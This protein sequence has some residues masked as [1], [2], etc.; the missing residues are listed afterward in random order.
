MKWN[1]E[2]FAQGVV[3]LAFEDLMTEQQ[4]VSI[5]RRALNWTDATIDVAQIGR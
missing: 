1:R 2:L 5:A 4:R 3:V